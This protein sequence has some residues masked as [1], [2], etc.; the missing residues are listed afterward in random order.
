MIYL[1]TNQIN[2]FNHPLIKKISL[3]D[4]LILLENVNE[5][6]LDTET[7]G[8]DCHTKKLLL[9]QL[10]TI[11]FQIVYDISS[12]DGVIPPLLKSFLQENKALFI[13][14]NVKFDA[15]F[16]FKQGIILKKVYDTMLA[17]I[18][19]TNGLQ[20]DGRDLKSLVEKYC[21]DTLDKEVRKTISKVGVTE[22]VILYGA[23]D[24]KYLSDIKRKQLAFAKPLGLDRAIDLDN[25]FVI[26]LAYTEFCGIKLD[27]E[28][29]KKRTVTNTEK[30]HA[31][32][33]QLE[34]FLWDDKKLK[35]FSGMKDLFIGE[36]ECII[37]WDSPKQVIQLFKDYG[38]NVT[39][40]KRGETIETIDAAV[41]EPQIQKFK[42]LK[43]YLT[44]KERQK[45]VSTYGLNWKNY[46]NPVTGRIHTTFQQLM[47]TGRLSSGNKRDGTPNL[48]N[49]PSSHEVRS[50]FI[51]EKG[52]YMID[53]DYSGQETIILANKSQEP[54]LLKFYEK[55]LNDMHSFVAFL[56]YPEIRTCSVDEVT[57]EALNY[58]KKN[59]ADKRQIAK[60]AGF[61]IA[62]GG[63]GATIAKNCN[64]SVKDGEFVYNSYFEAFPKM[65]EYFDL[66]FKRADH[67]GY[68]E[69]SPITKRKYFFNLETDP[70]FVNKALINE[71]YFWQTHPNPR[72]VEKEFSAAENK[73]KR[74]SQNYPIQGESADVT[75]YAAVLFFKEIL[76]RDWF[77]IVKMVNQV[78]DELLIEC[79]K[80]IVEEVKKVLVDC[81]EEAGKP[82]CRTVPLKAEAMHGEYWVH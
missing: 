57:K 56:M 77:M 9:L 28:A 81:M 26:V 63:N 21:G 23:K 59:H 53:A 55:G 34:K 70:Y 46:I 65:K 51:P 62:Y 16:L 75:K 74:L 6:G 71:K 25:S 36:Q 20:Y 69:Y 24:T 30:L 48:Q 64:I 11:D 4:S 58:V 17:E 43:P 40:K 29:W 7:E 67:F 78:H 27:F 37:N 47:N 61:A 54:N 39:I 49:I 52:N 14:Q 44:Y 12:Y 10:G 1:V 72:L 76:K 31:L 5:I 19:V 60:S 8:L 33:L 50:C 73:I 35:Y 79:P 82:F 22:A 38:I 32:K 18:I 45:E 2:M 68:I 13:L 3:E 42:I 66:V 15:K 80:D 41:L